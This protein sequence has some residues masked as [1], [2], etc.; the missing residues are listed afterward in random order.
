MKKKYIIVFICLAFYLIIMFL[1]FGDSKNKK[2]GK[3]NYILFANDQIWEYNNSEFSNTS[4]IVEIIGENKFHI[5]EN[6]TYIGNF[7]LGLYESKMYLFDDN[8]NSYK[9]NGE[10]MGFTD[11][12]KHK[13]ADLVNQALD[14]NDTNIIKKEFN[15]NNLNYQY[16]NLDNVKKYVFDIDDDNQNEIIY[17]ISNMFDEEK[18][19][20]GYS[21]IFINDNGKIY[22]LI[23]DIKSNDESLLKGYGYYLNNIADINNDKKSE[24]IVA[25][26]EYGSSR[27]CYLLIQKIKHKYEITK[28]C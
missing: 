11:N 28:N 20:K 13:V 26:S 10:L 14:E 5:Y 23:K 6:G 8:N 3:P 22:E 17:N 27:L 1:V 18:E 7:N 16:I 12:N 19:E 9:Y 25:K 24:F 21:L 2:N 15:N 4:N